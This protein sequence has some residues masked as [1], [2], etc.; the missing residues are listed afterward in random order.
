DALSSLGSVEARFIHNWAG[1]ARAFGMDPLLGRIHAVA[2]L[3]A[4]PVSVSHVAELLGIATAQAAD[5]LDELERWGVVTIAAGGEPAGEAAGKNKGEDARYEADGDPWSW[6]L[7]TIKERGRREFG[8]LVSAI[9]E[10]HA[11][12]CAVRKRLDPKSPEARRIDRIG[13]FSEFVDQIAGLLETFSTLG[14][15]PVMTAMRMVS[16]VRA[17]RLMRI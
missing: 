7:V 17:P 10:A 3:A 4:R 9:R 1:L 14:A 12:A 2:F 8:P 16:K 5:G 11:S 13:R 6:F 15:G